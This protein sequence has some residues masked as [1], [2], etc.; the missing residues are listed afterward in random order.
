MRGSTHTNN[1]TVLSKFSY[2]IGISG[3][4]AYFLH[5]PHWNI[6]QLPYQVVRKVLI[7]FLSVGRKGGLNAVFSKQLADAKFLLF[8]QQFHRMYR[9]KLLSYFRIL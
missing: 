6:L 2:M 3:F 5:L 9:L 8:V 1:L 7:N 4:I